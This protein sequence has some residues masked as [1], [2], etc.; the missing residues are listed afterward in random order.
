MHIKHQPLLFT[1]QNKP[2]LF[3]LNL[4]FNQYIG[5][6][7]EFEQIRFPEYITAQPNEI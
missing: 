1:F 6:T 2:Q 4:H 3:Q 7:C 5:N